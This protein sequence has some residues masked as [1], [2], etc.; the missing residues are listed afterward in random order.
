MW[1]TPSQRSDSRDSPYK[2]SQPEI[3]QSP[4]ANRSRSLDAAGP[5][6]GNKDN[7]DHSYKYAEHPQDTSSES[8]PPFN[9]NMSVVTTQF[10][11]DVAVYKTTEPTSQVSSST[12]SG[13]GHGHHIYERVGGEPG[14][15]RVG[16]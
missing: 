2:G 5:P 13:Y 7:Y 6:G 9:K 15:S 4:Y 16:E 14:R 12:D 11:K 10:D 8:L 3:R 1:R